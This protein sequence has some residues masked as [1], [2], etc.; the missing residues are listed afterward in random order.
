MDSDE[1]HG[2]HRPRRDGDGERRCDGGDEC[3]RGDRVCLFLPKSPVAIEAMLG[4]LKADCIYV[5]VD[6]AS[7]AARHEQILKSAEPRVILM[8]ESVE[9][10]VAELASSGMLGPQMVIGSVD[11][12]ARKGV[13]FQPTFTRSDWEHLSGEPVPWTNTSRDAAHILFTSGSTGT[14]KGVVRC[15]RIRH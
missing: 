10:R 14:P 15:L 9:S 4:T 7:P 1:G 5:P 6:V 8:T 3:Q 13:E 2:Y 12:G 11:E